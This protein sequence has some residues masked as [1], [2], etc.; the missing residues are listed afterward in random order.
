MWEGNAIK[1]TTGISN[2]KKIN[3]YHSMQQ[4]SKVFNE[5]LSIEKIV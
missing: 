4:N 5:T 2:S 3:N 1:L